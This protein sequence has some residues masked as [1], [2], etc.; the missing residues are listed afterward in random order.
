MAGGYLSGIFGAS[1]IRP[2]QQHMERV[3]AC[4]NELVPFTEAALS[5]DTKQRSHHHTRII[6]LE[7]EGDVLKKELRLHLPSSLFMPID[8]RDILEV[9]TMQ[10]RVAGGVK[11]VSG[12]ILGRDIQF[13]QA[14]A[15]NYLELVKTC[16]LACKQADRAINELDELIETGFGNKERER[17]SAMLAEL[18]SIEHETDE[19]TI[20]LDHQLFAMEKD[21]PPVDV[22]FLYKVLDKT[23]GIADRA[24]RVGSRLQLMLAR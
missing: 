4:V 2:L 13:P 1:P 20:T 16:V 23:S 19:Q 24:Q 5:G 15:E 10:D 18:D 17:V 8:R 7:H 22:M 3:V 11:D 9:L 21:L 14:M 6:E 12:I